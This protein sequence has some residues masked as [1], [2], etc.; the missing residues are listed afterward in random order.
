MLSCAPERDTSWSAKP[1]FEIQGS[2]GN[3]AKGNQIM[4]LLG[5]KSP[6]LRW[7][8]DPAPA[9]HSNI[10]LCCLAS[11]F[12]MKISHEKV[13]RMVRWTHLHSPPSINSC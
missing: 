7:K 13:E 8:C 4:S 9:W 10:F 12:I 11:I 3:D 2:G 6:P 1:D 5:L